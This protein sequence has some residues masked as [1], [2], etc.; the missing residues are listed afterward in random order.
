MLNVTGKYISVFEVEEREKYCIAN[1][2]TSK[3][4]TDNTYTNMYWRARFVGKA[5]DKAKKLKDKDKIEITNGII[6]NNY[7]KEKD[8]LWVTVTIFEFKKM[9]KRRL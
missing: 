7:D 5:F 3:K 4:N 1:L 6:E 2:S 9:K 8:K